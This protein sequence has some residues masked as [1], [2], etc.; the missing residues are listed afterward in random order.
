MPF[1]PKK[2]SLPPSEPDNALS[3]SNE[4]KCRVVFP[5]PDGKLFNHSIAKDLLK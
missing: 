4:E 1:I 3:K 5:T 2:T